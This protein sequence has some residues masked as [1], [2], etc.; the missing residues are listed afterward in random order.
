MCDG[1][2]CLGGLKWVSV[3]GIV[4]WFVGL[5]VLFIDYRV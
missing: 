5:I 4:I 1:G 2:I 3:V